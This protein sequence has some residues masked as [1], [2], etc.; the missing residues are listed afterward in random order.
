MSSHSGG[1]LTN[2]VPEISAA[3]RERGSTVRGT[4]HSQRQAT[5]S[6]AV[7][8]VGGSQLEL[9]MLCNRTGSRW[10]SQGKVA[11][12]TL[13]SADGKHYTEVGW[14]FAH[15]AEGTAF[16]VDHTHCCRDK[17]TIV[18]RA[19]VEALPT[20]AE[21]LRLRVFVDGGMIEAFSS[22]VSITALLNPDGSRTRGGPPDS[23]VSSVMSTAAG[24]ACAVSSYRLRSLH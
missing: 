20:L 8:L 16:Y 1:L 19:V 10:P 2:P 17:S 14:D 21:Q 6:P 4:L 12:R 24:V 5:A 23:R 11:L 22:G 7:R 3:L 13:A 15:Q 18:Q 9:D